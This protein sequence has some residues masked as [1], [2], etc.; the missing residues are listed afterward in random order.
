MSSEAPVFSISFPEA[1]IVEQSLRPRNKKT[2]GSGTASASKDR[3]KDNNGQ[4]RVL[5]FGKMRELAL[6]RAEVLKSMGYTV[7]VPETKADAI[8]T[9]DRG[10]FEVAILSYTLASDT[11]K[12]LAD[13]IRQKCPGCPLLTISQNSTTDAMVEPDEVVLAELGPPG[14]VAALRRAM[15]KRTQ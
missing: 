3:G 10:G 1:S 12:E 15:K 8:A 11:V 5:L 14:L 13:R 2:D 4:L 9:I 7:L 6:Y